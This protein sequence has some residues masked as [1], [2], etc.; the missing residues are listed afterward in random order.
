MPR[1]T[2]RNGRLPKHPFLWPLGDPGVGNGAN[3]PNPTRCPLL[4]CHALPP[5]PL[6]RGRPCRRH[7]RL[8]QAEDD[9]KHNAVLSEALDGGADLD[10]RNRAAMRVGTRQWSLARERGSD[11]NSSGVVLRQP[12]LAHDC[13]RR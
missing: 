5:A 3:T 10:G 12:T 7:R 8:F 13:D 2:Q 1:R 6:Q 9:E 4:D 11:A